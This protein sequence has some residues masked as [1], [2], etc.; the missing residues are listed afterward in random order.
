M[1]AAAALA[2]RGRICDVQAPSRSFSAG[3]GAYMMCGQSA[4]FGVHE[5]ICLSECAVSSVP[6]RSRR[7]AARRVGGSAA[8]RVRVGGPCGGARVAERR[9][10]DGTPV[11]RCRF[12][13]GVDSVSRRP[14][15]LPRF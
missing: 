13:R 7:A 11:V 2:P 10:V 6:V 4:A 8:P 15:R 14:F 9:G 3:Y 5:S 1:V 12:G